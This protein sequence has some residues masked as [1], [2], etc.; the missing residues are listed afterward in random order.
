MILWVQNVATN[1][2]SRIRLQLSLNLRDSPGFLAIVPGAIFL[3]DVHFSNFVSLGN[4]TCDLQ[5][6]RKLHV[7]VGFCMARLAGII[8]LLLIVRDGVQ[9]VHCVLEKNASASPAGHVQE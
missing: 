1:V 3:S 7:A 8:Q 2:R 6:M 5:R 9:K 4:R